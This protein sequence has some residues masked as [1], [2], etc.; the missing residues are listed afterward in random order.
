[1]TTPNV[2]TN[3]LLNN[4]LRQTQHQKETIKEL[5]YRQYHSNEFK[6]LIN[7]LLIIN[8][9][10]ND[11]LEG[12]NGDEDDASDEI[13]LYSDILK[14]IQD[15]CK[16][17][18]VSTME[19]IPP[20]LMYFTNF[21]T[22]KFKKE[23]SFIIIPV[24]KTNFYFKELSVELQ[25]KFRRCI[26]GILDLYPI[27]GKKLSLLM[28]PFAYKNCVFTM[29]LLTHEVAHY[30][31]TE[32]NVVN[33]LFDNI[34]ID[35]RY[36]DDILDNI[37]RR[38][39]GDTG[40]TLDFFLSRPT[41]SV[42]INNEIVRIVNNW[43]K[44]IFC[45]LYAFKVVGPAYLISM[46]EF[47]LSLTKADNCDEEHP[48][49]E[50]RLRVLIEEY[51]SS[52]YRYL[53]KNSKIDEFIKFVDHID[54]IEKYLKECEKD[55]SISSEEN[56]AYMTV[57]RLLPDIKKIV[58]DIVK[59]LDVYYPPKQFINDV[60]ILLQSIKSLIIPCELSIGEPA[61]IISILNSYIIYQIQNINEH[62]KELK[63]ILKIKKVKFEY[64]ITELITKG[65]ELCEIQKALKEKL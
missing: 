62:Y 54:Q 31:E 60:P 24:Y 51:K 27:G 10:I 61:D 34:Q 2:I 17:I 43:L 33:D 22:K 6:A 40:R 57:E 29:S 11:E 1:M 64:N 20:H 28:Y 3:L 26:S 53:L 56:Y 18:E 16:Y 5:S 48:P 37:S 59:K 46:I 19:N 7:N 30:V 32:Y 23:S 36:V 35:S 9:K 44:E 42:V 63:D 4:L 12:I 41:L 25:H 21:A 55:L 14:Y 47:I 13:I 15:L 52:N 49:L 39:V 65:V 45:D 8:E 38:R 50:M 58:N